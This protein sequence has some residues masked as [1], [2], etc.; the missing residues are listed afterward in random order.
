[1]FREV[2]PFEKH[3]LYYDAVGRLIVLDITLYDNIHR[4]INVYAPNNHERGPG[5]TT[6][7][8][9]FLVINY[10]FLAATLTV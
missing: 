9:G 3:M 5:L 10:V 4:F 7:T 1:M 2:F 8:D 6:C